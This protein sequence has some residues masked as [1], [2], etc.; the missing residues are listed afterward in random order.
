MQLQ[1]N[2]KFA[3]KRVL[4]EV[5]KTRVWFLSSWWGFCCFSWISMALTDDYLEISDTPTDEAWVWLHGQEIWFFLWLDFV[6]FVSPAISQG[7]FRGGVLIPGCLRSLAQTVPLGCQGVQAW[8]NTVLS[9]G[10]TH[11]APTHTAPG[12]WIGRRCSRRN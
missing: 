3:D 1:E 5:P 8:L 12:L 2:S 11:T 10:E 7:F 9:R 4:E 6:L